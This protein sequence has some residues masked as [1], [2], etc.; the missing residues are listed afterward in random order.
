MIPG[1]AESDPLAPYRW[2]NRVVVLSAPNASDATLAKQQALLQSDPSGLSNRD[3]VI[4]ELLG[5]RRDKARKDLRLSEGF[6]A[7]LVGKDGGVKLRSNDPIT[8]TELY[9]LVD[10]MPMRQREM[11]A[12]R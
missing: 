3:L 2:K 11:D 10:A 7:V 4:V 6:S 5:N 8:L 12:D 9:G 1:S